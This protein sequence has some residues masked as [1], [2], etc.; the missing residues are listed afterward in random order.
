MTTTGGTGPPNSPLGSGGTEDLDVE[1][2]Y[3]A[4]MVAEQTNPQGN[5]V[6]ASQGSGQTVEDDVDDK[7]V[8][9]VAV[10]VKQ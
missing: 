9:M 5:P 1:A 6:Q 7:V 2:Q 4:N 3:Q 8:K 10:T